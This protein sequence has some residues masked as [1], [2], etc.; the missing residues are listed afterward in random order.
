MSGLQPTLITLVLSLRFLFALV[1]VLVAE[2]VVLHLQPLGKRGLEASRNRKRGLVAR[3]RRRTQGLRHRV[4]GGFVK[5]A[6]F[7]G[8]LLGGKG[9]V[10]VGRELLPALARGGELVASSHRRLLAHGICVCDD[11]RVCGE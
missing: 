1:K 11:E 2:A 3:R 10:P 7:G 6:G 5:A 9:G 8:L 4:A